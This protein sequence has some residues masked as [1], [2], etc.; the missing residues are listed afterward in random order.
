M[1][2][3]S[4]ISQLTKIIEKLTK[5]VRNLEVE[6]TRFKNSIND[7]IKNQISELEIYLNVAGRCDQFAIS[8]LIELKITLIKNG[9]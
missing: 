7:S 6:N 9:K 2:N 3:Q 5:K 8:K 1:E 4:L